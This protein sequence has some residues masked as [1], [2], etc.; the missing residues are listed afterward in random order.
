MTLCIFMSASFTAGVIYSDEV[1]SNISWIFD[2]DSKY[3]ENDMVK[4]NN[5]R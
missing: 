3:Q 5:R 4:I 1:K 2:D